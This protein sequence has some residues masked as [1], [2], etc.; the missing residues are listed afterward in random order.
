MYLIVA[1]FVGVGGS[2]MTTSLPTVMRL[3]DEEDK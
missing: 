1:A 2:I 3:E